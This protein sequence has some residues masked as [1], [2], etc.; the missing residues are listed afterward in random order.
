MIKEKEFLKTHRLS[1]GYKKGNQVKQVLKEI[2]LTLQAG[3][4]VCF[5]GP[6]GVG[7]STLLR[8]LAKVQSPL[9]GEILIQDKPLH[10]IHSSDLAKIISLVLTEKINAGNL[11]VYELVALGRYPYTNWSGN[12]TADDEKKIEESIAMTDMN[13]LVDEK[14]F[15][16]SDGQLQKAMIARALAQDGEIMILD[17]PTAH[18]DLNNRVEIMK[19]LKHLASETGKAILVS[20]HELELALQIADKLWLAAFDTPMVSGIPEDLAL[21]GSIIKTFFKSE[22]AFNINTGRFL[23]RNKFHTTVCLEGGGIE[24]QWTANAL[25]REGFRVND[26]TNGSYKI[27]IEK[28]NQETVWK[29]YYKSNIFNF[30]SIASLLQ[31]L[32]EKVRN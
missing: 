21:N 20:T 3:E 8:T 2:N 22:E 10:K 29:L 6:N 30:H 11:S 26:D 18:L 9:S 13:D 24:K 32:K 23:I 4:L 5:L 31:D 25:E 12:L 7:K 27:T 19:L 15:E 14:T 1:I 17:E 16:L 28:E